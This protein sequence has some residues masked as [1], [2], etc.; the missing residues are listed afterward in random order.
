MNAL[1]KAKPFF[2]RA[3]RPL[4]YARWRYHF[5][6]GPREAVLDALAD[7]QNADGGFGHALE[8]DSWNPNSSPMQTWTATELLLEI[9]HTDK[10]HPLVQGILR[11][12]GSG[13]DFDGQSWAAV[14][15]SNN[16]YP[17][18]PWW[19]KGSESS[20]HHSYNP[21]A[22]LAGFALVYADPGSELFETAKRIAGEAVEAY[23]AQGLL[24][25]MHT[26]L[27]YVRL[28][29]YAERAE[30]DLPFELSALQ[31]RL[32]EQ[33]R[34]SLTADTAEW[35]TGYVCRP[36]RFVRSPQSPFYADNRELSEFECG[37]LERTQQ[38]DGSWPVIWS[39]DAFEEEWPVSR[40]AWKADIAI[41]NLLYLKG[42]A[43][44]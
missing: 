30:T 16:D 4:D 2:A 18:A 25:D 40:L 38:A 27:C 24:A 31:A 7:Y 32:H 41:K 10:K 23:F 35:E 34:Y 15:A 5:E 36:S 14:I 20:S 9:G 21:T 33:V 13:R 11:Y 6:G 22:S 12:L 8:P 17:H 28:M 37:F 42:F 29:E 26:A 43:R 39:W 3:A 44:L 19:R 1:E